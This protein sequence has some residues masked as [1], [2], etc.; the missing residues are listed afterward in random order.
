MTALQITVT[1]TEA[2][3]SRLRLI[4]TVA[5]DKALAA[6]AEDVEDYVGTEA[7]QHTVT[8]ALFR[9]I[10]RRRTG[11]DWTIGHDL[12]VAPYAPFVHWGT[13]PHVIRA[14]D[15]KALRW[16]AGGKFFFAKEVRHPGYKGDAW[17]TRAAAKAPA[18]FERHINAQLQ[19]I[20]GA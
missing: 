11:K 5:A 10:Y 17:L 2:I 7:G 16:A 19:R 1:G 6:T 15:K 4:G 9:S 13:R 14:K 8:G 3:R 18:I 12:R 20:T